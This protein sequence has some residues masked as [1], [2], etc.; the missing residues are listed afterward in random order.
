MLEFREQIVVER[1]IASVALDYLRKHCDCDLQSE[2]Q[3]RWI[4]SYSYWYDAAARREICQ[5][6]C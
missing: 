6:V 4:K 3:V 5:A 2:L 1:M